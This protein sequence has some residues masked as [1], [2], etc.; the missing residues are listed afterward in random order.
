MHTFTLKQADAWQVCGM[1]RLCEFFLQKYPLKDGEGKLIIRVCFVMAYD[2][3]LTINSHYTLKKFW[4][5]CPYNPLGGMLP[6]MY[7]QNCQPPFQKL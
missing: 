3:K 6:W 7:I 2:Q 1:Q 5:A 4:G